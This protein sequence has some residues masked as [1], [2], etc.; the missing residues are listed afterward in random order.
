M[1]SLGNSRMAKKVKRKI[2]LDCGGGFLTSDLLP[3]HE[4]E[5]APK[6]LFLLK[7]KKKKKEKKKTKYACGRGCLGFNAAEGGRSGLSRVG[8]LCPGC[9]WRID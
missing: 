9:I 2:K 4:K 8:V 5:G 3:S 6:M 7:Q 1:G